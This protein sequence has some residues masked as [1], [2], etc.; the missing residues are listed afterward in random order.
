MNAKCIEARLPLF[1][2]SICSGFSDIPDRNADICDRQCHALRQSRDLLTGLRH[3]SA[4]VHRHRAV[5]YRSLFHGEC[6]I[7]VFG[8]MIQIHIIGRF[9]HIPASGRQVVVRSNNF[10]CRRIY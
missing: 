1:V 8:D 4:N 3:W 9:D 7:M 2:L 10:N 5:F 6:C